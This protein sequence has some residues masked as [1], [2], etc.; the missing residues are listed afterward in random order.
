MHIGVL[1]HRSERLLGEP[2]WLQ[3]DNS[4]GNFKDQG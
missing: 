1:R 2:A 4:R 3:A